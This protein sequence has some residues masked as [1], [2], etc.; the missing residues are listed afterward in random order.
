MRKIYFVF[1]FLLLIVLVGC[2]KEITLSFD[3]NGAGTIESFVLEKGEDLEMPSVSKTG[4][5]FEGWFLD[6]EFKVKYED[7]EIKESTTFY[8]KWEVITFTVLFKDGEETLKSQTVEYGKSATPPTDLE[9]VGFDFTG[10]DKA[11]SNI[12]SNLTVNA[13]YS[14]ATY[15]VKFFD[16][17][18]TQIGEDVI[19]NHGANV[20]APAN[21]TRPGFL[22]EGWD[23]ELTN[24]T[25]DLEITATYTPETYTVI[26]RDHDNAILKQVDD[27]DY[28]ESVT[29]PANPTRVGYEFKEWDKSFENI[30]GDLTIRATYTPIEYTIEYYDGDELL[31]HNPETYTILDAVNLSTYDKTDFIFIGWYTE[32]ELTTPI[33]SIAKGSH[34]NVKVYGKWLDLNNKVTI[35]YELNGGSWTWTSATVTTPANG[36]DSVSNLPE[37]FMQDYYTYLKDNDLLSST[38]VAASL[39]KTD[40]NTFKANYTDPVAIY[41]HTS[42]NVASTPDGYSQFF[43]TSATGD[44]STSKITSI[45]GGF[46]GT[47]PYKTKYASIAQ[48][49][50]YFMPLK[51]SGNSF[52]GG[53]SAK[54]LLGFILDGYFYGT[55]GAGTGGV[56]SLRSIIPN[57]NKMIAFSNNQASLV[58]YDYYSTDFIPGLE[59]KLVSPFKEGYVFKGWYDNEQFTGNSI[60]KIL[61]DGTVASKYYAKWEAIA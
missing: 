55:Q 13:T 59:V 50:A 28:N 15:V 14:I 58:D 18:E 1:V 6:S 8:A 40:W 9:K 39:R 2:S 26:F 10:W 37:L 60:D 31:E 61:A 57:T 16:Y 17:D 38:K 51:Y 30:T 41:N 56:L 42:T 45:E 43:Y 7:Q 35:N 19:V 3:T 36:I 49:L 47:E 24:I 11:F 20:T 27:V 52:W 29:P 48:L 46:F 25:S 44:A 34:E 22:F 33:E 53:E 23:H 32:K 5:N 21:P 12:T 54:A 4:F